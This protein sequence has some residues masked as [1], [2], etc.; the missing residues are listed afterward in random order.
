MGRKKTSANQGNQYWYQNIQ[1]ENLQASINTNLKDS[2]LFGLLGYSC[3][4]GVKRNLG[5][6]G[7]KDAPNLIKSQL[8]KYAFHHFQKDI[9]DFGNISCENENLED[10]QNSLSEA[11]YKLLSNSVFPI[12]IGGGTIFLLV[13]T[14]G[15]IN[16]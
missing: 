10:C 16:T 6:V 8:A 7:A 9:I 3:E 14:K 2:K 13:I 12:I 4:E 11:V 1:L 5:R 15:F